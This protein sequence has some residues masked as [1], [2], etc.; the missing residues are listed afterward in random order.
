MMNLRRPAA[1]ADPRAEQER[2]RRALFWPMLGAAILIVIHALHDLL[3]G[4]WSHL[5]ILP[6]DAVG[7]LGII[8]SP[9]IHGSWGHLLANVPTLWVLGMLTLY[10]FPRATRVA[11]PLIWLMGGLGVWLFG[12]EGLHIG[13]SGLTHGLMFF[14]VVIGIRRRDAMSIAVAIIILF[15]YGSMIWGVF[16][17]A[18]GVSYEAHLFGAVAGAVCGWFLYRRDP[19]PV[20][21]RHDW[22]DDDPTDPETLRKIE[23]GRLDEIEPKEPPEGPGRRD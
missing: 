16:P 2:I 17:S 1:P 11:V 14:A 22:E 19:F 8:T 13:A 18:P 15:L 5:G 12:R 4:D 10:G 7:T 20:Y 3:G 6:R 9:L 23:Q 21:R